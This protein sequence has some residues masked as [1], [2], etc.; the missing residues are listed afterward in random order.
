MDL[1]HIL[2]TQEIFSMPNLKR[3]HLKKPENIIKSKQK[4]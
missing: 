3:L 4:V 1:W 2:H